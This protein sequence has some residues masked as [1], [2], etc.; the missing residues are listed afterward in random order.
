MLRV[1]N[2]SFFLGLIFSI[3]ASAGVSLFKSLTQEL[4]GVITFNLLVHII[5]FISGSIGLLSYFNVG[6]RV[7]SLVNALSTK[8]HKVFFP[9]ASAL[10]GIILGVIMYAISTHE[11]TIALKGSFAM[12]LVWGQVWM[13]TGHLRQSLYFFN[14]KESND[15]DEA[16]A[17]LVVSCLLLITGALGIWDMLSKNYT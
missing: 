14:R 16:L 9:I 17:I 7:Q 3:V 13:S 11:W 4:A 6:N 12:L 2:L 8:L 5:L 10:L 1:F 15:K